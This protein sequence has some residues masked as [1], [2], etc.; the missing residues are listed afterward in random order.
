MTEKE[1]LGKK[2]E[3]LEKEYA[4]TKHNKATNKHLGILRAKISNTKKKMVERKKG[5]GKG[6]S[7]K[8]TGDATVVLVGFPNAGKSSLQKLL[9]HVDSKVADYA[10]TT[11]D[12]IPGIMRYNGA[13]I[14]IF[15]LPGLIEGAH[16]G[17]GGGAQIASVIRISD[18]ICFVIDSANQQNLYILLKELNDLGIHAGKSKPEMR[19]E[20]LNSGGI[21]I[22][23]QGH[24]I[25]DKD[26]IVKIINEFGIFNCAVHFLNDATEDDLIDFLAGSDIYIDAIV[27]INKI[28]VNEK[29]LQVKA[30]VES[31]TKLTVI[32]ISAL[33][34]LNIEDLRKG[35]FKALK[36]ARI[37]LKPK[38]GNPDYEN[39]LIVESKVTVFGV[40]KKL[41]SEIAKNVKYAY[42]TGKSVKFKNQ[43]VGKDH[44]LADEDI[45]TLVYQN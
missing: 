39:P 12:A 42:V 10:F 31:K 27:A 3:E 14:Q 41:H 34:N 4:K 23:N 28:D 20:K 44:V 11:I 1:V 24:K 19:M 9:T 13:S 6:Y 16:I 43:K 33:R 15:D 29:Y 38:E 26:A 22:E 40:A 37:Y 35:I 30:E 32:P 36:I 7:V 21:R 17:K 18:L 8:K 2:L 25:P 5:K 45:L